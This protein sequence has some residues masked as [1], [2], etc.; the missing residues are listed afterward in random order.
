[1]K[2]ALVIMVLAAQL[3]VAYVIVGH[4]VLSKQ[5]ASSA[6]E[7][8]LSDSTSSDSA[9]SKDTE[10]PPMGKVY[11]LEDIVVNPD[12]TNGM[13]YLVTSLGLEL[14]DPKLEN[15]IKKREPLIRDRLITLLSGKGVEELTDVTRREQLR[16]ELLNAINKQLRGGKVRELY[17]VKYVLQ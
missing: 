15:E 5:V 1:M 8:A 13:R 7:R 10:P 14:S 9:S 4:L 17:F 12:H 11:M 16:Q 3:G 2:M 6:S